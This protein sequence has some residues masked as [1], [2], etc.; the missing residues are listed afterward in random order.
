MSEIPF[1]RS[2]LVRTDPTRGWEGDTWTSPPLA[3]SWAEGADQAVASWNLDEGAVAAIGIR[4]HTVDGVWHDWQELAHWGAPGDRRSAPS[5]SPPIRQGAPRL[6]TDVLTA[7]GVRFDAVQLRISL[8]AGDRAALRLVAVSFSAPAASPPADERPLGTDAPTAPPGADAVVP[9]SQRAHP[10]REDLGGGGPSWC[11]PT[12]LAMVLLA[13]GADI[14]RGGPGE[15]AAEADPRVPHLAH[16]VYDAVYAGTGNWSFN[17]AV[18][19][20]LG[21][22]AVV[23]RLRSL[24]DAEALTA[25]GF[26]LVASIS[27]AE[28]ALPGADY[29]TAG[30]LLVLRG[31]DA[32]G[33]VQVAD[34]ASPPLPSGRGDGLRTYP[35]AAFDAAWAHSRRTAWLI[36]PR[37][38]AL[39]PGE[40]AGVW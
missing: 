3:A 26:P 38:R 39:P 32:K 40:D 14:P 37:G 2:R 8:A 34:P 31:F 12:S 7:D 27:F 1:W 36:A 23:T 18:A 28:G 4:A 15:A 19:G 35:R 13:W 17:A 24:Q 11:A 22:D 16:A 9:L 10:A 6:D 30:H 21:F 33:D 29:A 25:A 20:E 5:D